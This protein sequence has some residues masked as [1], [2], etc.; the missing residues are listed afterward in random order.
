MASP[1][2]AVSSGRIRRRGQLDHYCSVKA[3]RVAAP[4]TRARSQNP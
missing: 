3:D 2:R 4:P 1:P